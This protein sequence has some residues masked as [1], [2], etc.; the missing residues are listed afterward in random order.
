MPD[1]QRQRNPSAPVPTASS[2][3]RH[4]ST[5]APSR[6][7]LE[8]VHR[9]QLVPRV[10]YWHTAQ[11]FRPTARSHLQSLPSSSTR[12]AQTKGARHSRP[13]NDG[14][15]AKVGN[16]QP[17]MMVRTWQRLWAPQQEAQR[18]I[19]KLSRWRGGL[20][21]AWRV[22]DHLYQPI[23]VGPT[24]ILVEEA[25]TI[26]LGTMLTVLTSS[27]LA[28]LARSD[29]IVV[30]CGALAAVV[31]RRVDKEPAG[32]AGERVGAATLEQANARGSEVCWARCN[33]L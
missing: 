29:R 26:A 20:T 31:D 11:L 25:A 18:P 27:V 23:A 24:S 14:S 19:V 15:C 7:Y 32:L 16:R 12:S 28:Y 3:S 21:I 6:K 1:V 5:Q 8:L 22:L 33:A 17:N 13:S 9:R 2:P 30:F 10:L 4:S